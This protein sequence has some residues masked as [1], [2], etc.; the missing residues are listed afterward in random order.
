MIYL[1][2]VYDHSIGPD[3]ASNTS[4]RERF[5]TVQSS[6]LCEEFV[7]P[8]ENFKTVAHFFGIMRTSSRFLVSVLSRRLDFFPQFISVNAV[9]CCC[10]MDETGFN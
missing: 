6:K 4:G 2:P 10:P 3:D 7:S 9:G 5:N 1:A 8:P